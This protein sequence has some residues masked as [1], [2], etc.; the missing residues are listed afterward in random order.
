[1][2]GVPSTPIFIFEDPLHKRRA[3]VLLKQLPPF[4]GS[5]VRVHSA[6]GLRD[7]HGPVHAGSFLRER[8]IALDCTAAEFPRIFM[9]ELFHFAW[10]RA[11]NPARRS[12]E[13]L[14]RGGTPRRAFRANSA[15]RRNGENR[16][17]TAPIS[18]P[19]TRRWREYCCESFCDTAAWLYSGW[20]RHA[21]FTLARPRVRVA[22]E[23]GFGE[24][25]NRRFLDIIS[26]G[27]FCG[28]NASLRRRSYRAPPG[29]HVFGLFFFHAPRS[30]PP[31][32]KPTRTASPRPTSR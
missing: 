13:R 22:A 10:V 26:K 28:S 3:A 15:G 12:F 24:A 6:R 32:S 17:S 4:S 19:R 16:R 29:M 31:P 8:R 5:P 21:E 18:A 2:V 1:M 25:G 11:G 9:H 7:R 27:Q 20:R 14:L 23:F 30:A